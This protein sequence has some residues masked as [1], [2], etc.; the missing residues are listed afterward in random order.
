MISRIKGDNELWIER[1]MNKGRRERRSDGQADRQA[2]GWMDGFGKIDR[3][4]DINNNN[5]KIRVKP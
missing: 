4:T 3:E 2:G 1:W 5:N